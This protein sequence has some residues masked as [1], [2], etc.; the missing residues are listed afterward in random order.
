MVDIETQQA[1]LEYRAFH[2]VKNVGPRPVLF[3]V[4]GD[5]ELMKN[6]D[7]A[8]AAYE[9]L[10][11]PKEYIEVPGVTHFEMYSGAPFERSSNAA[12]AWFRKHFGLE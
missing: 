2:Y 12:A 4:A 11:G 10:P 8:R 1:V 7:H 6:S 9:L 3:V 5:E